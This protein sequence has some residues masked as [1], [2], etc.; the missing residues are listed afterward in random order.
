MLQAIHDKFS[1]VIKP[2]LTAWGNSN[3]RDDHVQMRLSNFEQIIV[4][5]NDNVL[6]TSPPYSW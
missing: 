6:G 5:L 2:R 4:S 3:L 1:G